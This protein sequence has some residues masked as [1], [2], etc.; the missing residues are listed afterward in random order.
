MV[1]FIHT[2]GFL[3]FPILWS[4]FFLLSLFMLS[5]V[6]IC[7]E[8]DTYS[9][10]LPDKT[11]WFYL[12]LILSKWAYSCIKTLL[13]LCYVCSLIRLLAFFISFLFL[14]LDFVSSQL[15]LMNS[16]PTSGIGGPSGIESSSGSSLGGS[17]GPSGSRV[18]G[19]P[20]NILHRS[21]TS[22]TESVYFHNL[23][24]RSL[25][26]VFDPIFISPNL[27]PFSATNPYDPNTYAMMNSRFPSHLVAT[28]DPYVSACI[29]EAIWSACHGPETPFDRLA[30][31]PRMNS[32]VV[33]RALS[34]T[35]DI[36]PLFRDPTTDPSDESSSSQL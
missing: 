33:Q 4:I 23:R 6:F 8:L 34:P 10:V 28:L 16:L 9:S 22:S 35:V 27:P 15:V 24:N 29:N 2:I 17:Q 30:H 20:C 18:G 21:S 1:I 26:Y 13:I 14:S 11:I 25:H 12:R 19:P 5:T 31:Y 7:L 36:S 32:E 3:Y